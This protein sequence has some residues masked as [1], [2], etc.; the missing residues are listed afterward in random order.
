MQNIISMFL[1][2]LI[3][4]VL[5]CSSCGLVEEC[6]MEM[7]ALKYIA[8][9]FCAGFMLRSHGEMNQYYMNMEE[10]KLPGPSAVWRVYGA[11]LWLNEKKR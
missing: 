1:N 10:L 8:C 6:F 7:K 9:T 3:L 4:R 11:I 2:L 5:I